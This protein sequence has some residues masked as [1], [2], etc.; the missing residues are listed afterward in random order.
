MIEWHHLVPRAWGRF[1]HPADVTP[2]VDPVYGP[3]WITDGVWLCRN[4]HGNVHTGGIVP[5]MRASK[6]TGNR[7]EVAV[8]QQGLDLWVARGGSLDALRA[9]HLWGEL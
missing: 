8:A 9:A 3:V 1:W 6:P 2:V 5:L 4:C 7:A